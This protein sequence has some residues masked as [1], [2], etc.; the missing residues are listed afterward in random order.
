MSPERLRHPA[1]PP[2]ATVEQPRHPKFETVDPKFKITDREFDITDLMFTINDFKSENVSRSCISHFVRPLY[3]RGI[4]PSSSV[5]STLQ[6]C[7]I[8][9]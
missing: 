6:Q 5:E 3:S 1:S 8:A 9:P 7:I 2:A 4:E